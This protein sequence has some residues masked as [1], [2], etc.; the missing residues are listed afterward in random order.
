MANFDEAIGPAAMMH[1]TKLKGAIL[2]AWANASMT[3]ITTAD[4]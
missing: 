1:A 3:G 2:P 4:N